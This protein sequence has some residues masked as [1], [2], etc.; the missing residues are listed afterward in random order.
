MGLQAMNCPNCGSSAVKEVKPSTYFCDHCEG[1]FRLVPPVGQSAASTAD[2]C[3]CGNRITSQCRVCETGLCKECDIAP[4]LKVPHPLDRPLPPRESRSRWYH[5]LAIRSTDSGYLTS[6]SRVD[7][8]DDGHLTEVQMNSAASVEPVVYAAK[9]MRYLDRTY[10]TIKHVCLSCLVAAVPATIEDIALGR[11]CETLR[12]GSE[13]SKQCPC[14]HGAFCDD[15]VI[16]GDHDARDYL[17][18]YKPSDTH[19]YRNGVVVWLRPRGEGGEWCLESGWTRLRSGDLCN[20]CADE[21]ASMF[22]RTAAAICRDELGLVLLEPDRNHLGA[23][24]FEVPVTLPRKARDSVRRKVDT[25]I[26]RT[27]KLIEAKVAGITLTAPCNRTQFARKIYGYTL[28]L[29]GKRQLCA[30]I[31]YSMAN[32]R[33]IDFD[34]S[35]DVFGR[36][37]INRRRMRYPGAYGQLRA[38]GAADLTRGGGHCP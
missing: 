2:F 10:L 34:Q 33:V 27:K 37:L 16:S 35:P 15:H 25:E 32:I 6:G 14:C 31:A 24:V 22:R 29:N 1:V 19:Q 23:S 20:M 30:V 28:I 5:G 12:C 3:T 36:R 26:E 17:R 21:Q 18:S 8:L 13:P 9:V 11:V 4:W 7:V 38:D